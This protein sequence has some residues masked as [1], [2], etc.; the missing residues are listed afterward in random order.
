MAT[1]TVRLDEEAEKALQ[2]VR[3]ATG[4]PISEALKR[5]LRSLQH[6]VRLEAGRTPYDV[7]RELDLGP[8]GYTIAPSTATRRGVRKAL[9]RK[10]GR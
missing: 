7:Y 4:L 5:G 8:G 1:R 2:E 3:A 9:R 6:Q 10:L